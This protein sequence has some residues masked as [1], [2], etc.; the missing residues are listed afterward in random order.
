[1]ECF[2]LSTWKK[3]KCLFPLAT[4]RPVP[5]WHKIPRLVDSFQGTKWGAEQVQ[6]C[7]QLPLPHPMP[8]LPSHLLFLLLH[9]PDQILEKGPPPQSY[10]SYHLLSLLSPTTSPNS[11]LQITLPALTLWLD[12]RGFCFTLNYI[13]FILDDSSSQPQHHIWALRQVKVG[14]RSTYT[15][16]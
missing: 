14:G 12:G 2:G 8:Y 3:G 13:P 1:M 4:G 16:V 15:Q 9:S 11:T 10:V 7:F 5:C 6:L